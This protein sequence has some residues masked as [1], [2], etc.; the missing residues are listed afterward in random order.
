MGIY[1]RDYMRERHEERERSPYSRTVHSITG[2]RKLIFKQLLVWSIVTLAMIQ[3][4]TWGAHFFRAEPFPPSGQAH[5]W[6]SVDLAATAPLTLV[7]PTNQDKRYAVRLDDWSS[8]SPVVLIPVEAGHSVTVQVP[9]GRYRVTLASGSSWFGV[10]KL[11]GTFGE[12]KVAVEPLDFVR[13]NASTTGHKI[14]LKKRIDGN[15]Q[16]RSKLP[17][18][19]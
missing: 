1:D 7:A 17:V 18:L 5:W 12:E 14:D 3:L 10:G 16:T 6:R 8:G 4:A 15:M 9:L 19:E 2:S 13:T 11:F